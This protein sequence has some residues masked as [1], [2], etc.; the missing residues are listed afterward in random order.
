MTFLFGNFRS[1]RMLSATGRIRRGE[2]VG[3]A[4]V[5]PAVYSP[6]AKMR[7]GPTARMAVLLLL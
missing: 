5:S 6:A 1:T 3:Q 4:G 7:G 2:P